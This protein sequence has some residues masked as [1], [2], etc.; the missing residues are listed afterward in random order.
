MPGKWLSENGT[1]Y[2]AFSG[3]ARFH[4]KRS[5]ESTGM[6]K[7]ESFF[8]QRVV[9]RGKTFIGIY[10]GELILRLLPLSTGNN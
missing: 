5:K 1:G 3:Q 7:Y 6:A 9:F 10:H 4:A 8:G 2:T